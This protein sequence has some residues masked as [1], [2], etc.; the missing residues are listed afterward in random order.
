MGAGPPGKRANKKPQKTMRNVNWTKMPNVKVA[1]SIWKDV[2][3][4]HKLL[5]AASLDELT[6]AFN[7]EDAAAAAASKAGAAAAAP[8][9]KAKVTEAFLDP[10]KANT[11]GI[12]IGRWSFDPEYAELQAAIVGGDDTVLTLDTLYRHPVA[13]CL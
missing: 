10:K 2:T 11:V 13:F 7:T 3:D 4:E 8:K 1:K 6:D 12:L 5:D 9:K